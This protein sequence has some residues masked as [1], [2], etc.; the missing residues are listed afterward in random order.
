MWTLAFGPYEDRTPTHGYEATREAAMAAFAKSWRRGH[1][2]AVSS[3]QP[4][5]RSIH[6]TCLLALVTDRAMESVVSSVDCMNDPYRRVTW[7]ATS[8]DENS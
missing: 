5:I 8:D 2:L 4:V 6:S 3:P 1:G 7:Q